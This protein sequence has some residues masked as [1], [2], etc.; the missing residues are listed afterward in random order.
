M[1][2]SEFA[3]PF[4]N[5]IHTAI[6]FPAREKNTAMMSSC[7][8]CCCRRLQTVWLKWNDQ[9]PLMSDCPLKYTS[10]AAI[11]VEAKDHWMQSVQSLLWLED[12]EWCDSLY[13]WCRQYTRI[14]WSISLL[15]LAEAS[16]SYFSPPIN[17]SIKYNV[18][19]Y[20]AFLSLV[21]PV[22]TNLTSIPR[23]RPVHHTITVRRLM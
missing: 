2:S 8:C 3:S 22:T 23:N 20:S 6:N 11:C 1:T 12:A 21:H 9:Q 18:N 13:V 17:Q 5:Y 15:I 4:C 19:H 16:S 7:C 10:R 14:I